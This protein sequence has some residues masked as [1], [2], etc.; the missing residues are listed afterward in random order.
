[1]PAVG[2]KLNFSDW[3]QVELDKRQWSQADLARASDLSRAVI[4]KLLNGKTY[5]QPTTLQAI[6]RA[7]KVPVESAYRA[8]GLL[9]ESSESEFFVSEVA[10]KLSLIRDSQR[11]TTALRLLNALI[12][13]EEDERRPS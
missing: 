11:R 2:R 6:A 5:P 13:E 1:M 8:A 9:P 12:D 7:F 3:L 4:N 10:H